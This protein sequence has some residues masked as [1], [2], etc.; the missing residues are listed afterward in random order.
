MSKVTIRTKAISKGR[1]SIYLDHYPPLRNPF[2][3]KLHRKEY[4]KLYTYDKPLRS[5]DKWHN[6]ETLNLVEFIRASRQLDV[7]NRRFGFLSAAER[8]SN[9]IEFFKTY[10]IR[11]Q[12]SSSDNN[13]MAL[14]YFIA[15]AGEELSYPDLND[16][17]CEDYKAYLLS[18]PGISRTGRAISKNTAV[19]YYNKLRIVLKAIYKKGL[20]PYDLYAILSAIPSKETNRERLTL[21]EFQL[22]V[23][24][25][26][27]SEMIKRSCIFSG[28]TGLRFGDVQTLLWSEVRGVQGGYL[29]QFLQKKTECAEVLPI[30]DQAFKILGERKSSDQKVFPNLKYSS[31]RLF[32][33]DWLHKANISKNI[34]FHSFRHTFATLQLEAGTDLYTVS[35]LLGHRSIKTT[36][37]YAKIVDDMKRKA[38]RKIV[39]NL[40]PSGL[41][42]PSL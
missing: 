33:L 2:T 32:F 24:L 9:F 31:L 18:G 22:L 8:D 35:K 20:I 19:I 6:K 42:E 36:E 16:F 25:P 30:S 7:Q 34:T 39:L 26:V 23:E 17:L 37:V 13:A 1:H 21:Q 11:K 40:E 10:T 5:V 38:S 14:R 12:K 41:I 29:L 3:G 27:K 15:F 4:L 28:L